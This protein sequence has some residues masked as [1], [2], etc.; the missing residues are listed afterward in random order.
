MLR[1]I[2]RDVDDVDVVHDVIIRRYM[3]YMPHGFSFP[4]TMYMITT[5]RKRVPTCEQS[6]N[7]PKI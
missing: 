3:M 6:P 2:A 5:E 1:T 7:R 4:T